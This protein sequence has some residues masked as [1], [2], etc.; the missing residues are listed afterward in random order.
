[1]NGKYLLRTLGC[2]VNQY[3]SQQIREILESQG[4]R[5]AR[6]GESAD[7]AVINS[8]AVTASASAKT[9]QATRR[10]SQGGTTP[11]IVVGCG[12]TADADRLARIPGVI[13]VWGHDQDL[14]D[15]IRRHVVHQLSSRPVP[16]AAGARVAETDAATRVQAGENEEWMIAG[17]PAPG[18]G[19]VPTVGPDL[20]VLSS[21]APASAYVNGN[22]AALNSQADPSPSA[23]GDGQPIH[24]FADHERAFLKIQDGC[25]AH[26]TYC[27]IPRL[28]PNLR[29]KSVAD[30]VAEAKALVRAGHRE[31]V[32]TGIY[33]GAFGRPTAIRKRFD[34]R[35]SPLAELVEAV[36]EV[37]GLVR[38]RLSSLEPG[39]VSDELLDV[40]A[41]HDACV[42]HLHLP[43]QSGS[44]E[45]LR[46]MNR[47][48]DRADF[49]DM[50]ERVRSALDRAAIS[51]DILVGFPGETEQDFE[52][53]VSTAR[54]A[55]FCKIH[56]FPFSPRQQTAAA[57]WT[58]RFVPGT[59]VRR[60]MERLR[61]VEAELAR[62]FEEQCVGTIE[63]VLIERSGRH[64][65]AD[66][67]L[68]CGRSDRYF[69]VYFE[70]DPGSRLRPGDIAWV[71]IHRVSPR[72]VHGTLL[73]APS[74]D[75][76]LR[77]LAGNE[78]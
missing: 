20:P 71:R 4:L 39:D 22:A 40:L 37:D 23:E 8:C 27:I 54:Q 14:A 19:A 62:C 35:R 3:E 26:C 17:V 51:T 47:Q 42:P 1:M 5:P 65:P 30:A 66:S 6:P 49:L 15:Q 36:A 73:G 45:I 48:Y 72:R 58:D 25:D 46:R 76:P 28:R 64:L 69:R 31:I 38:L 77:V 52:Q 60:R 75:R 11:T 55:G 29:S 59:V 13:G 32:L 67:G 16:E 70:A 41:T 74:L 53:T 33:L 12:A 50:I 24:R 2:K 78:C 7:L 34:D 44:P 9:R 21:I 10:A 57:R 63:R 56:A 43:L 18:P 68:L 61:T